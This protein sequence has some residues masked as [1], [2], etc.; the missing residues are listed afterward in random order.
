MNIL[1]ISNILP[2]G[3]GMLD[4][5]G[6]DINQFVPGSQVYANDTSFV[7]LK[8]QQDN[9]PQHEDIMVI[10]EVDYQTEIEMLAANRPK[11]IEQQIAE[12]EQRLQLIQAAL[13]DLIL[14]GAV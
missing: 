7:L 11:P 12:Q 2:Q 6:L 13:D 3:G 5:K 14:G 1:K 9:I 8:T 10:S 4:Y